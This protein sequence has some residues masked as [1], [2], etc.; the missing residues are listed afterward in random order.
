MQ[1]NANFM[2]ELRHY[3][4]N[5]ICKERKHKYNIFF[6]ELFIYGSYWIYYCEQEYFNLSRDITVF[7]QSLSHYVTNQNIELIKY[8][9]SCS[10]SIHPPT[11]C[12]CFQR[13]QTFVFD[14]F[15]S[16]LEI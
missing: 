7:T 16:T 5:D 2:T 10:D 4:F 6:I 1:E 15:S 3:E 9:V 8:Q 13:V 11:S 14:Y 12:G